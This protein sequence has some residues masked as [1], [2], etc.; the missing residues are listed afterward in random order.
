MY[1]YKTTEP[2]QDIRV[3][4][5]IVIVAW[6]GGGELERAVSGLLEKWPC[7]SLGSV[8]ITVVDNG[9]NDEAFGAITTRY[10]HKTTTAILRVVGDATNLGFAGACNLGALAVGSKYTIVMNSDVYADASDLIQLVRGLEENPKVKVVGPQFIRENGEIWRSCTYSPTIYSLIFA[11]IFGPAWAGIARSG[12]F[13]SDWD[14]AEQRQV[15]QVI[16]A[17][18]CFRTSDFSALGGFDEQFFV[19]YE[20]VD[21]CFRVKAGKGQV[22]YYPASRVIHVGGAS[23]GSDIKRRVFYGL[24]SRYLYSRKHFGATVGIAVASTSVVAEAVAK[25]LVSI[26][27]GRARLGLSGLRGALKFIRWLL[28]YAFNPSAR[29]SAARSE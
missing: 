29:A 13:M 5:N 6:R 20:E 11:P 3:W 2:A 10:S 8:I 16:G 25:P 4:L 23:S 21:Y 28:G 7:D 9:G 24:R 15:D 14:H 1:A 12:R 27:R 18:M 22:L 26:S 19:Y 17:L